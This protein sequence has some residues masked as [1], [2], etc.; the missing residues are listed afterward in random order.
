MRVLLFLFWVWLAGLIC[1][2][3]LQADTYYVSATLGDDALYDGKAPSISGQTGPFKTIGRAVNAISAGDEIRIRTGHYHESIALSL[4]GAET[5]VTTI[6]SYI[7]EEVTMTPDTFSAFYISESSWI[8]IEGIE[9]V[10]ASGI[11][12]VTLVDSENCAI[13]DCLFDGTTGQPA[14]YTGNSTN[15]QVLDSRFTNNEG[16]AAYFLN[17]DGVFEGNV[18]EGNSGDSTLTVEGAGS[19]GLQIV[20]NEF[21][22]NYPSPL[23]GHNVIF[24]FNGGPGIDIVGNLVRTVTP[25]SGQSVPAGEYVAAILCAGTDDV[26]IR[27]NSVSNIQ[28]PGTVDL[29]FADPAYIRTPQDGGLVGTGIQ[30]NGNGTT[31]VAGARVLENTVLS[32]GERGI[33]LASVNDSVVAE[34]VSAQNGTYGIF[35]GGIAGDHTQVVRNVIEA[36]RTYENGW[37]HGGMSGI[38]V[39]Q[40]GI[41]NVIRRNIS[42]RNRQGTAGSKG[43][44]WYADGHGIIADIDSDGTIIEN[45]IC[46]ENEGAGISI[47]ESDDCVVVNN[48]LVG[49]GRCPHW[50]ERPGLLIGS[51]DAAYSAR[52]CLVVNNL[53]YNNRVHQFGVYAFTSFDHTVHHN[54]YASGPLTTP[55]TAG[56]PVQWLGARTLTEWLALWPSHVNGTG[57]IGNPPQFAGNAATPHPGAFALQAASEGINSGSPLS[58]FDTV[59]G[60]PMGYDCAGALRDRAQPNIGAVEDFPGGYTGIAKIRLDSPFPAQWVAV[61]V[62]DYGSGSWL[63]PEHRLVYDLNALEVRGLM[64]GRWYGLSIWSYKDS[65]WYG[66][67]VGLLEGTAASALTPEI[68]TVTGTSGPDEGVLGIENLILQC[69]ENTGAGW[70]APG[71]WS[72]GDQIWVDPL[73]SAWEPAQFETSIQKMDDWYWSGLWHFGSNN[74]AQGSWLG[75]FKY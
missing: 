51:E 6:G 11:I 19:G 58:G 13:I 71:M 8:V 48:T 12:P 25:P 26:T 5:S 49:N 36:N 42:Y 57:D 18:L 7:G 53:M 67:F 34:N 65:Q 28:Y 69:S 74:W 72:E 30:V 32:S 3:F 68:I 60:Y 15:T 47:T 63:L 38:S 56:K 62:W 41:G 16:F 50:T 20:D 43:F 23:K 75:I 33:N 17:T 46:F 73:T 55:A 1:S 21:T 39:W 4:E 64:G 2:Q 14:F 44:D 35:L 52:R 37:Q 9:F 70:L 29:T 24:V 31:T 27:E 10:N 45:N 66:M 40:V 22:D 54:L 59:L 61:N